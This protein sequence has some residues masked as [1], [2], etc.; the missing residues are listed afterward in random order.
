ME[1]PTV[2]DT[3]GFRDRDRHVL[4][5]PQKPID[6]HHVD[7]GNFIGAFN[8]KFQ[9][10]FGVSTKQYKKIVPAYSI[11]NCKKC[12]SPMQIH[13]KRKANVNLDR[14]AEI[15]YTCRG[16]GCQD[17]KAQKHIKAIKEKLLR[18]QKSVKGI[19]LDTVL[20]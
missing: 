5:F 18:Q 11:K 7:D 10:E 6:P 19:K 3:S 1:T 14:P 20:T 13:V 15:G 2:S 12:G 17:V 9:K 4:K 16:L 8:P